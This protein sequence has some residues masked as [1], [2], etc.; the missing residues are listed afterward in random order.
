MELV[1][2]FCAFCCL[3]CVNCNGIGFKYLT[4]EFYYTQWLLDDN[5]SS[6]FIMYELTT[7]LEQSEV[8]E[9]VSKIGQENLLAKTFILRQK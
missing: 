6:I 9:F 8:Q 3:P 2:L 1:K 5:I 7:D 4:N